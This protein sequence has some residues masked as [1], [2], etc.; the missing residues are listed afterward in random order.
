MKIVIM[1]GIFTKNGQVGKAGVC[2]RPY[3]LLPSQFI[4]AIDSYDGICDHISVLLNLSC[5]RHISL[6]L[7][8]VHIT[9]G[10]SPSCQDTGVPYKKEKNHPGSLLKLPG[11][12]LLKSF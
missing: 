12:F 9:K 4:L 10:V 3:P 1:A 5:N 11:W 2:T 8:D 7:I 6:I